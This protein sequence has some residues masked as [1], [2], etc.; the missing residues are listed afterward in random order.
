MEDTKEKKESEVSPTP[1][2]LRVFVFV[3]SVSWSCPSPSGG[4]AETDEAAPSCSEGQMPSMEGCVC[5][6]LQ[7][8]PN[9]N[10]CF[11]GQAGEGHAGLSVH[12]GTWPV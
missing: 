7:G 8:L 12:Q 1:L 10:V 3:P 9:A 5:E 2:F 6:L 4:R 11:E